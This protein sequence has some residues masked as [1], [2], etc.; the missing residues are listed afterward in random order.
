MVALRGQKRHVP[1]R[2]M[3]S[4]AAIMLGIGTGL[5]WP[6]CATPIALVCAFV[7]G[8]FQQGLP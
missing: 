3:D 4:V 2:F 6:M 1:H 8:L 7:V 5:L